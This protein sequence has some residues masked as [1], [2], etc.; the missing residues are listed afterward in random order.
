M[1]RNRSKINLHVTNVRTFPNKTQPLGLLH[2]HMACQ[3]MYYYWGLAQENYTQQVK[4]NIVLEGEKDPEY[5][6]KQLFLTISKIYGVQPEE[7]VNFWQT[8]RTQLLM[9]G[10]PALPELEQYLFNT[11][12]TVR[13]Q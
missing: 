9:D 12:I 2:P 4:L 6:Y 5:N 10:E 11:P 1:K 7:M 8:V 3:A 13:T